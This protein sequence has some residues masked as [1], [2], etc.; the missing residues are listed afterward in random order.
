MRAP[1]LTSILVL[2]VVS[3]TLL[4]GVGLLPSA[5]AEELVPKPD[6]HEIHI[7]D[8]PIDAY[9][10]KLNEQWA[11]AIDHG[12]VHTDLGARKMIQNGTLNADYTFDINYYIGN[13]T[14]YMAQFMMMYVTFKVGNQ[15]I[16]APLRS[17]DDF[18][19][20][21]TPIQYIGAVPT[22][23]CN[24][25]YENINIYPGTSI[26]STFDLTL[27]HHFV[28]GWNET[29]VKVEAL[30]D[31]RNVTLINPSN[32]LELDAGE[33]YA[34][35]IHYGMM[36]GTQENAMTPT[37]HTNTSLEYNLTLEN[38]TPLTLSKFTMNDDFSVLNASG[39]SGSIGYSKIEFGRFSNVTHGFPGLIYKDTLSIKSDPEI[40][41]FHDMVGGGNDWLSIIVA[42][43]AIALVLAVVLLFLRRKK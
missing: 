30:F 4:G 38:G 39:S 13:N 40:T 16:I 12:G 5:Q 33:Q 24:I 23:W 8:L 29:S 21:H 42:V 37:G 26:N 15:T 27:C 6:I 2:L 3:L 1:V 32:D 10:M 31:L 22:F 9:G 11:L 7:Y 36:V 17:C 35:E 20:T 34:V 25:T 43:V 14:Q 28:C 18:I 19:L 41:V